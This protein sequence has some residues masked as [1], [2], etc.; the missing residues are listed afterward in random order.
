MLDFLG[1]SQS[2][3]DIVVMADIEYTF[4][5]GCSEATENPSNA[6]YLTLRQT[7][8]ILVSHILI[9]KSFGKTKRPTLEIA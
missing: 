7:F 9:Y 2:G 5:T 8:L 1:I 3:A 4:N 6:D